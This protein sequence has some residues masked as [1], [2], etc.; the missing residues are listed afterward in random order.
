M[1]NDRYAREVVKNKPGAMA[2]QRLFSAFPDRWPGLGLL[3]LRLVVGSSYLSRGVDH[4]LGGNSPTSGIWLTHL[5]EIAIGAALLLGLLTPIA[6]LAATLLS[7][8]FMPE[9][10]MMVAGTPLNARLSSIDSIAVTVALA[11]LGPGAFSVD[12]YLFGRRE[13]IIPETSH[14][15]KH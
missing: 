6:S 4:L 5:A 10:F 14:T 11:L 2:L 7:L 9:V 13:I 15:T 8:G 1:R 3:L 12:A